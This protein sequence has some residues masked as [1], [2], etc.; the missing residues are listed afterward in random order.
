MRK[1]SRLRRHGA[2][3]IRLICG[4]N[5]EDHGQEVFTDV[6]PR[7]ARARGKSAL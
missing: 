5:N 3:Q 4:L 2:L 6:G 1:T 7:K